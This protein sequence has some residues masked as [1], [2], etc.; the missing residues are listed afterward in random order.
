MTRLSRILNP[1]NWRYALGELFLIATGVTIALAVNA[2]YADSVDRLTEAEYLDRLRADLAEDISNFTQFDDILETK[3]I[4]LKDLITESEAS[5][6]SRDSNSLMSALNYSSFIALTENRS[7][8]FEELQSTGSLALIRDAGLRNMLARYYSEYELISAIL[9]EPSGPYREMLRSSLPGDAVYDW[10]VNEKPMDASELHR[11]LR[12][13]MSHPDLEA[14]VNS[15]LY[16]TAAMV[17]YLRRF[18]AQAEELLET[19]NQGP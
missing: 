14:A 4:T 10:R 17:F 15:E 2:W 18:R 7:T 19:V 11:G 9:A 8:T 16:Y 6:F 3:A 13:L 12:S 1:I 5:L